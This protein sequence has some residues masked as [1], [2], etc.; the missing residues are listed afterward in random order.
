M[1]RSNCPTK[2]GTVNGKK[3]NMMRDAG[4]ICVEVKKSIVRADQF[5]GE[6][7]CCKYIDGT[8]HYFSVAKIDINTPYFRG[9][10]DAYCI[11]APL[12]DLVIGYIPGAKYP[13]A[14]DEINA[15]Q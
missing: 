9:I 7:R 13:E 4:A 8:E 6:Q 11:E 15:V 3:V 2:E 12:Y 10:T 5:T 14:K 1:V